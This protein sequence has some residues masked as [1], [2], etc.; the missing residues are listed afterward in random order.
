MSVKIY[1]TEDEKR[2]ISE[3]DQSAFDAEINDVLR[4]EVAT[5]LRSHQASSRVPYL[6][7][8]LH[9]FEKALQEYRASKSAKKR[10]RTFYDASKAGR[11]LSYA[12]SSMKSRMVTEEQ[13]R[14][15]F[16]V[17]DNIIWPL[18]FNRTFSVTV[19]FQWRQSLDDDW[20]YGRITF[21]HK[22]KERR[23]YS[24]PKPKR[25]PSAAQQAQDLQDE[26]SRA[27]EHFVQ[28]ALYSVRDFF[29]EGGD[30]RDIPDSFQAVPDKYSMG[31][32]N[33][34]LKFWKD[35]S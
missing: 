12:L 18:R 25:K 13:E 5:Q 28:L 32:N 21:H 16:R 26:L 20:D 33:F 9:Y 23:D 29:R 34:S 27:W 4:E 8:K 24:A 1:L 14:Q 31:L 35:G 10:E 2:A 30:G 19:S 7:S 15:L 17:D 11:D 6:A 22:V 3:I